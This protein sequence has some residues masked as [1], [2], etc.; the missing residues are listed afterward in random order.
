MEIMKKARNKFNRNLNTIVEKTSIKYKLTPEQLHA[1]DMYIKNY[2]K[3]V[4]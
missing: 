2:R 1:V 4:K 3:G